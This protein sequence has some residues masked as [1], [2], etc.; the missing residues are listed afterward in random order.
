MGIW[1]TRILENDP[2]GDLAV[3]LAKE[4]IGLAIGALGKIL[5]LNYESVDFYDSQEALAACEVI[6]RL[7]GNFGE[8]YGHTVDVDRWLMQNQDIETTDGLRKLAVDAIDRITTEPSELLNSWCKDD[9][10]EAWLAH[11]NELRRRI[12]TV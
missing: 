3:K 6:A 5:F 7:Q 4:G 2:A 12:K 9:D 11:V 1:G 10:K 8:S